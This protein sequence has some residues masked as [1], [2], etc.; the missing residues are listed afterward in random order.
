MLSRCVSTIIAAGFAAVL[1]A[2]AQAQGTQPGT[3]PTPADIEAKAQMCAACHGA[4]GTPLDAKTM[5][6]I[7]GQQPYYILTQLVHYRNGM[8]EN[9]VMA[10]IAKTLQQSDL[11]PLAA[12]FAA[13][14]WPASSNTPAA[15]AETPKGLAMCTPCH[16]ANFQGGI[17]WP[18]IAGLNYDYMVA[19][20]RSFA[21]E[22]R[23][24]NMDMVKIMKLFSDSERDAMARYL[25]ALK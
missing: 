6:N 14:P 23:T 8:R 18:R 9:P 19:A 10:S 21:N 7:W 5:P 3:Q 16:Q 17:S 25:A 12:Y 13:K 4:N 20:M 2:P 15:P 1:A 22:E 11:R 24:N